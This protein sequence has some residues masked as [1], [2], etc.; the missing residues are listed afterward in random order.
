MIYVAAAAQASPGVV[1]W[2]FGASFVVITLGK[3]LSAEWA[4]LALVVGLG[5]GLAAWGVA[6]GRWGVPG[7]LGLQTVAML[8]FGAVALA[9]YAVSSTAGGLLVAAGLAAHGAWDVVHHRLNRVVGRSYAE[10]CAVLDVVLAALVVWA[11]LA[12]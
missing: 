11:V 9:A 8:T 2:W 4:P 7:G 1:W 12:A 10:F 3:A 5:L 6:R